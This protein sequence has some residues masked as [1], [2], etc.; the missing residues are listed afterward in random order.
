MKRVV[1]A[2]QNP[3]HLKGLSLFLP[4]YTVVE[5]AKAET[6]MLESH[7]IPPDVVVLF[8]DFVSEVTIT[9]FITLMKRRVDLAHT[10]WI[11]LGA[12][13]FMLDCA[14]GGI[15][16]VLTANVPPVLLSALIHSK[17]NDLERQANNRG[18]I[19][20]LEE[21]IRDMQRD[22]KQKEQLVHMLVHDL[23]NPVSAV[24]GLLDLVIDEGA[25]LL[26]K[27]IMTLIQTAHEEATHVLYMAANILDVRKMQGGKM[28]LRR[29]TMSREDL[30]QVLEGSKRDGGNDM[31]D[32]KFGVDLPQGLPKVSADATVLRRI[33]TNLISNAVKHTKSGGQI[34]VRLRTIKDGIE[35]EVADNGEGIPAE[36]IPKLFQPFEQSRTTVRGRFDSG[37]GLAFCKLAVEQHG[38]QIVVQ[39]TRG[40]GTKFI[41]VL[42]ILTGEEDDD[43]ELAD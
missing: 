9:E 34:T 38:G 24:M 5:H 2:S 35:F 4:D 8:D 21:R 26:P 31:G 19:E 30:K 39:S 3:A 29:E 10:G 16:S 32:R 20:S 33:L 36:D 18:R 42:P 25:R 17:I 37:M 12:V 7:T 23:K 22:D 11:A 14:Q 41:F 40:V 15:D 6:L 43:L 13:R 1:I 28:V 27:D